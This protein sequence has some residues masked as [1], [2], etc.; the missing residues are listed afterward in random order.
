M[1]RP[2]RRVALRAAPGRRAAAAG[3]AL[4]ALAALSFAGR[5]GAGPAPAARVV[6]APAEFEPQ[7][8]VWLSWPESADFAPERPVAPLLVELVRALTPQVPVDLVVAGKR[9]MSEAREALSGAGVDLSSVR[10][11]VVAGSSLW[12]RDVGPAFVRTAG[13]ALG[14]A[15]FG[16]DGWGHGGCCDVTPALARALEGTDRRIAALLGLPTLA[17]RIVSEGGNREVNGRGAMLS[18]EEVELSRNPG[19]SRPELEEE[20]RRALGVT[21]VV[22]LPRGL[23]GDR[24]VFEGPFPG[25]LF[26]PG[27]PG[28]HVDEFARF[29]DPSTVLLAEVDEAEASRSPLLAMERGRLEESARAVA[30]ARDQDGRPFRV[31]RLPVPEPIVVNVPADD[32]HSRIRYADGTVV[33]KGSRV[34]VLL[35][36]S[37]LNFL[38]TNGA[39]VLPAY[40]GP[41]G[42]DA[43]LRK[44][45]EA[46]R[47]VRAAFPGRTL[48]RLNPEAINQGGGGL[49]CVTL[50]QPA[51]R[52]AD[53]GPAGRPTS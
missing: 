10:W 28:G 4:A 29:A 46:A 47:V 32:F 37:Y 35:A 33:P 16:F 26:P 40:W 44:D 41:G 39:V 7:E 43:V 52:P 13:G 45:E 6:S 19:R 38:V 51:A 50:P 24:H 11:H 31:V 15:D 49:H 36:T 20:F 21:K 8:S 2:V 18:V 30:T 17:A 14:V 53:P 5:L 27:G 42:P 22:W 12:I 34:P 9:E 23:A 3:A 1:H 25:G 48:I